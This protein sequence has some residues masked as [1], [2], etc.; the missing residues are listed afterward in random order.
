[1]RATHLALST[2]TGSTLSLT[3]HI[4]APMAIYS[5]MMGSTITVSTMTGSTLFGSTMVMSSIRTSFLTLSTLTVSSI[6]NNAPGTGSFSTLT[7]SSLVS[8]SSISSASTIYSSSIITTGNVG[9][10]TTN[11][12]SKLAVH[13]GNNSTSITVSNGFNAGFYTQYGLAYSASQYSVNSLAGDTVIDALGGNLIV[14]SQNKN[15]YLS[16]PNTNTYN[17]LSIVGSGTNPTFSTAGWGSLTNTQ[18][19]SN[20]NF[21]WTAPVTCYISSISMYLG[22]GNNGTNIALYVNGNFINEW[23]PFQGYGLYV[24]NA[25]GSSVANGVATTPTPFSALNQLI[26]QAGQIVSIW[27]SALQTYNYFY[28]GLDSTTSGVGFSIVYNTPMVDLSL[29]NNTRTLSMGLSEVILSKNTRCE[30]GTNFTYTGGNSGQNRLR[31]NGNDTNQSPYIEF[32]QGNLRRMYIGF[33]SATTADIISENGTILGI[34]GANGCTISQGG[35][36]MINCNSD[37]NVY[38]E[39][40]ELIINNTAGSGQIRFVNGAFGS[41]FRQDGSDLHLL[42][43]NSG[44]PYGG[45]NSLKPFRVNL[46][47]GRVTMENGITVS[48]ELQ[49]AGSNVVHFGYNVTKES[50]AGKIGYGTFDTNALC[51][52]GAGS[53]MP[54]LVKIWDNLRVEAT[55]SKASGT[56]DIQHPLSSDSKDRLV[57]SFIEGPRCDLIYRGKTTLING[58]AI[59]DINK[60]CTHSPECAMDEGTF[61]ALCDNAECFLQ[62]KTG[63]TRVIGVITGGILTI[64]AESAN[65]T[66]TIVWMVIA[67]RADP[68]IK[69]WE[70]T[71]PDGYLITQYKTEYDTITNPF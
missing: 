22:Q 53:N 55:L 42:L 69:K 31:I 47:S 12:V 48:G 68:F 34:S 23:W 25:T 28:Y 6:N 37:G 17:V 62:N 59:V 63:F 36:R 20:I 38:V 13:G 70:R 71:N 27:I 16:V 24:I 41:F 2:L 58:T 9:I 14:E 45:W 29:L 46:G 7:V 54:R 65:V 5:T 49:I 61:E 21:T 52:V 39:R 43:T 30:A 51:I 3:T 15:I 1:M 32:F 64:T 10:G 35:T 67:E 60:E 18:R 4:T 19:Y 56:F 33:C 50:N 26:V 40:R 57:H 66:D 11:L 8:V 44:D